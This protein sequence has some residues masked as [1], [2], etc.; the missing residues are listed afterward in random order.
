MLGRRAAAKGAECGSIAG[1]VDGLRRCWPEEL[2]VV[3]I[4]SV[5]LESKA[6]PPPP[7][8]PRGKGVSATSDAG[9]CSVPRRLGPGA[10]DGGFE[11]SS[12]VEAEPLRRPVSTKRD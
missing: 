5:S 4:L 6:L 9:V 1:F 10:E 12:M 11:T 8:L 2:W 7:P 3:C